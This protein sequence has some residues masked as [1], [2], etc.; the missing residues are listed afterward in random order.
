MNYNEKY[1]EFV[2]GEYEDLLFRTKQTSKKSK[3][4]KISCYSSKHIRIQQ[5][6]IFSKK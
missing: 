3:R 4:N 2:Y 6:K 1:D 5:S